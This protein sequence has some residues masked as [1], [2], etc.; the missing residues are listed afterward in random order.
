MLETQLAGKITKKKQNSNTPNPQPAHSFSM[1]HYKEK[2][3]G[4]LHC[5][6]LAPNLLGKC[7]PTGEQI[8][9]MWYPHSHPWDK[10]A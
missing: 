3:G 1:P 6:T 10:P 7:R 2:P 4:L 8:S 9:G 5:Q